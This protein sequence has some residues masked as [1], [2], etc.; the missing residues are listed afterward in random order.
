M[1]WYCEMA[2]QLCFLLE[3]PLGMLISLAFLLGAFC[4]FSVALYRLYGYVQ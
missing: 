3:S 4:A 1:G 2:W